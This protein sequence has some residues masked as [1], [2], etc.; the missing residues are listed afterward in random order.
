MRKSLEHQ[1][2][3]KAKHLI[4]LNLGVGK[5]H[6]K[7]SFGA[8]ESGRGTSRNP[9]K[10]EGNLFDKLTRRVQLSRSRGVWGGSDGCRLCEDAQEKI[11]QGRWELM[12]D[13]QT[14]REG[15]GGKR[16]VDMLHPNIEVWTNDSK[17]RH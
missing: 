1:R 2:L 5:S 12:V 8:G 14:T 4:K 15:G 16:S 10:N 13:I 6:K 17:G 9:Y 7:R 11:D 3:Q